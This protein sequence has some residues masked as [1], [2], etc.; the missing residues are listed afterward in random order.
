MNNFLSTI[1]INGQQIP[2]EKE[3]RRTKLIY[4]VYIRNKSTDRTQ[5]IALFTLPKMF[6]FSLKVQRLLEKRPHEWWSEREHPG[7]V[8]VLQDGE[9]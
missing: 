5:H 6:P 4:L 3:F 2:L 8:Y 7:L 9:F 1:Q